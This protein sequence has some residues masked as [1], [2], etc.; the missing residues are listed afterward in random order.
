MNRLQLDHPCRNSGGG[1]LIK[2]ANRANRNFTVS[3]S[4]PEPVMRK[5]LVL[6][7]RD[8]SEIEQCEL[9]PRG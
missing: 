7:D 3:R 8:R 6:C 2:I 4:E 9:V 5:G 1:T